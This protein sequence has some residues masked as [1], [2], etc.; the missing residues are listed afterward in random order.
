VPLAKKI[1]KQ[2]T[3][4]VTCGISIPKTK[5]IKQCVQQPGKP[6]KNNAVRTAVKSIT[7]Q[8]LLS[9]QQTS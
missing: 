5:I 7:P 9:N 3:K 4:T 2:D 8:K 1:A 6:T